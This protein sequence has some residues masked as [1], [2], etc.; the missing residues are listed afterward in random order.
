MIDLRGFAIGSYTLECWSGGSRYE[1]VL[2][3]IWPSLG[4]CWSGNAGNTVWVVVNGIRSNE[5]RVPAK[6]SDRRVEPPELGDYLS[7]LQ[8]DGC[9]GAPDSD[10]WCFYGGYGTSYVAWRLN[11]VNFKGTYT[12]HNSYI[13]S[14]WGHSGDWDDAARS[15]GIRVSGTPTSGSVAQWERRPGQRP[16][17]YAAYV[18]DVEY[19]NGQV[20]AIIIS[21]LNSDRQAPG[22]S[23]TWRLRPDV[24]C[25]KTACAPHGWPD[26]FIHISDR[27]V[28]STSSGR[29]VSLKIGRDTSDHQRCPDE[30]TCNW[31]EVTIVG[32]G[33]GPWEVKCATKGLPP[34]LSNGVDPT[35]HEVWRIYNTSNN[36]TSGC[37]FWR[38]GNT[39]YATV[40]GV[41][42]N[43]LKWEPRLPTATTPLSPSRS[44][45]TRT[46]VR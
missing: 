33:P 37:M 35:N 24:R 26:N 6:T 46:A 12:F 15:V 41:R 34:N 18:E 21:D 31:M 14:P 2:H 9:W 28:E 20:S 39:V 19:R 3:G 30:E 43:D 44:R 4:R 45:S 25:T 23:R 36:P 16:Y 29:S 11:E 8:L 5:L 13:A 32:L 22:D 42:S 1:S 7:D 27:G 40:D 38:R 10:Q 17:G